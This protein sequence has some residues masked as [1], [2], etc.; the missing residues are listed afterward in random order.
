L[1]GDDKA[2]KGVLM[3][4]G[5]FSISLCVKNIVVSKAFYENLGFAF[6]GAGFCPIWVINKNG[7]CLIP[8]D[9]QR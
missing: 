6:L 8:V 4:F 5:A 9:Q 2:V 1:H 3:Q 7:D